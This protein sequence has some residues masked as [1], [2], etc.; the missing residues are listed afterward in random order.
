VSSFGYHEKWPEVMPIDGDPTLP[1]QAFPGSRITS[2][3]ASDPV[4]GSLL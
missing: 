2:N 4:R 3:N 1:E